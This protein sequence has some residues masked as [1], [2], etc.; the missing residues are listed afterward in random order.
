MMTKNL[1]GIVLGPLHEF[2]LVLVNPNK[3]EFAL[4]LRKLKLRK[5]NNFLKAI[6]VYVF[7]AF[8]PVDFPLHHIP[9]RVDVFVGERRI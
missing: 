5:V 4:Y 1:L 9:Y 2:S 6:L 7:L 8:K 3:V